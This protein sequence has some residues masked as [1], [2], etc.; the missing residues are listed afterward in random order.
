MSARGKAMEAF[1]SRGEGLR[2]VTATEDVTAR[3]TLSGGP[4]ALR[5]DEMM[6][7][8]GEHPMIVVSGNPSWEAESHAGRAERFII[9]PDGPAF[10]AS[11]AVEAR[12][13]AGAGAGGDSAPMELRSRRM[14]V[15]QGSAQFEGGVVMGGENWT[16]EAPA[17]E[18]EL[19]E[20][21]V[22]ENLRATGGIVLE[23]VAAARTLEDGDDARLPGALGEAFRDA[24]EAGRTWVVRADTMDASLG[25]SGA[26]DSLEAGDAVTVEHPAM[27][28]SGGR[29]QYAA[30]DGLLRLV[31]SPVLET[32][33][34]LRILGKQETQFALDPEA[35]RFLVKGPV[36]RMFLPAR[37]FSDADG[38]GGT[39]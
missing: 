25:A 30:E 18:A 11:T 20:E 22:I 8:V 6:Y 36:T 14:V 4:V 7:T 28:A 17:A 32:A 38:D 13:A 27:R 34:G 3:L 19:A 10:E 9:H 37:A 5:G 15:R 2:Q 33:D 12:W 23:Y 39:D 21:G 29:L 1:N 16:I 24:D 26:L 35:G 31:E